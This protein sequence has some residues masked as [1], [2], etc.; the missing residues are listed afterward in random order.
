MMKKIIRLFC[1]EQLRKRMF[2]FD[3]VEKNLGPWGVEK[4]NP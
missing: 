2:A 3:Q 1:V 4:E